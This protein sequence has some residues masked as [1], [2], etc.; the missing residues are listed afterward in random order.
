MIDVCLNPRF[1]SRSNILTK[2]KRDNVH[3]CSALRVKVLIQFR[4]R[5]KSELLVMKPSKL[6][7]LKL[8]I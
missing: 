4:P 7:A 3:S 8:V 6:D 1:R 5:C 2:V